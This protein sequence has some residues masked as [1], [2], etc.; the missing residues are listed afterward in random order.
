VAGNLER[1]VGDQT[2]TPPGG[3]F[4][5]IERRHPQATADGLQLDLVGARV[6]LPLP[7]LPAPEL[8]G[9]PLV[10]GNTPPSVHG[11]VCDS[12]TPQ[13]SMRDDDVLLEVL[14]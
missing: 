1:R 3:S 2:A 5:A 4:V 12:V 9:L 6:A 14:V 8:D 10:V 7:A 11:P 13:R